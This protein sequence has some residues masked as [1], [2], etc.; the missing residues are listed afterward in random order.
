MT[1]TQTKRI[2]L[3]DRRLPDYTKTEEMLN[4][5][6]HIVGGAVGLMILVGSVLIG[7]AHHNPWAVVSGSIY[8]FATIS[9]FAGSS[10]YHGL[11][12]GM[13]KRVMQVI[14]HCTIYMLIAGTYTPI[15]LTAIRPVSPRIAW[16]VF[17]IEWGAALIAAAFTAIDLKKYSKLS[18]ICYL[19]MGWTIAAVFKLTVSVM[20]LPGFLWLLAGGI[21]Y[22]VGAVLY[23]LG[24]KHRYMHSIF[25]IFVNA[26]SL[27]QAI[28]ILF[29]VL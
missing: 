9:L 10:I 11:P 6:T 29:Y 7:A 14:D 15:V 22:T 12:D 3:R 23:G 2:P 1:L 4:M 27:L 21:F 8:G 26:G 28:A 5:I 13:A 17:G 24:K 18:M 25:H 19:L 16:T 20:T